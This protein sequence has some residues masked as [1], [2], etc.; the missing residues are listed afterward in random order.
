MNIDTTF[1]RL[2]QRTIQT[3][4]IL[5]I[6]I[7]IC[8]GCAVMSNTM[9][10]MDWEYAI[11]YKANSAETKRALA[12]RL[13]EKPEILARKVPDGVR[14]GVLGKHH[15]IVSCSADQRKTAEFVE[16][17]QQLERD[18]GPEIMKELKI[19]KDLYPLP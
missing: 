4:I 19:I 13:L 12:N 5:T 14:V 18:L 8:N 7:F 2:L 1:F 17:I 11:H 16:Y 10:F 3:A 15:I 6:A 9:T